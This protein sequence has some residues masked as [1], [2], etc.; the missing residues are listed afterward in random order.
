M[1]LPAALP[2]HGQRTDPGLAC[3]LVGTDVLAPRRYQ[4]A[5]HGGEGP[6]VRIIRQRAM[7]RRGQQSLRDGTERNGA[8]R[9]RSVA[10]PRVANQDAGS[11][12]TASPA[13]RDLPTP[14]SPAIT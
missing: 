14:G 2:G 13:S 4:M 6:D 12:M 7:P 1:S 11:A 5:E 8:G 10:R 3:R 9:S